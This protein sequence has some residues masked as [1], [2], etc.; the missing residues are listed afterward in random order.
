[1]NLYVYICK[2][3]TLHSCSCHHMRTEICNSS[4][5]E[6]KQPGA[7]YPVITAALGTAIYGH[8]A[9]GA[10][11]DRCR[12]Q[13]CVTLLGTRPLLA[14]ATSCQP[15]PSVTW[16]SSP[17]MDSWVAGISRCCCL[18]LFQSLGNVIPCIEDWCRNLMS[19]AQG[20]MWFF[21]PFA[22]WWWMGI[23]PKDEKIS[24]IRTWGTIHI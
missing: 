15:A 7:V 21:R 14:A 22:T 20:D 4:M 9:A 8:E 6:E 12:W 5:R 23:S 11:A 24:L 19:A 3:Q 16:C 1:M 18:L 17:P 2:M 10:G 13:G